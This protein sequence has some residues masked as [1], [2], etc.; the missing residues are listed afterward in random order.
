MGYLNEM[1]IYFHSTLDSDTAQ[2][3]VE[4]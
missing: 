3:R 2:I 4:R 1:T